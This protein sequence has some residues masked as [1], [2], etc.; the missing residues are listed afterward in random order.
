MSTALWMLETGNGK[1]DITILEK[2][3]TVP[4]PDAA[5]TGESGT[6]QRVG[7]S[8]GPSRQTGD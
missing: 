8:A 6:R 1:Y 2:C 5:S 4:A 7:K 3:T